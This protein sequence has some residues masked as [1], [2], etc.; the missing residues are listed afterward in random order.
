MKGRE[1]ETE[2]PNIPFLIGNA[3]DTYSVWTE[4]GSTGSGPQYQTGKNLLI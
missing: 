3:N 2:K 4:V 1:G